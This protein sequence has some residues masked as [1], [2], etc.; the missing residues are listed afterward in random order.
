MNKVVLFS[1]LICF[2]FASC[3][4]ESDKKESTDKSEKKGNEKDSVVTEKTDTLIITPDYEKPY[5][6]YLS[7]AEKRMCKDM[8]GDSISAELFALH[9]SFDSIATERQM[10]IYFSA[11]TEFQDR[12]SLYL[13][14]LNVSE[15]FFN[16]V[17]AESAKE[18]KQEDEYFDEYRVSLDY[19]LD[20]L[21]PINKF[22]HGL[23]LAC[24]AECTEP[25]FDLKVN[26]LLAKVK[27]TEG[28]DDDDFFGLIVKTYAGDYEPGTMNAVWFE[29]TWDLGGM[30]LLGSGKH[31]E[32]FIATDKLLESKN[33]F[34]EGILYYR[35]IA[36]DDASSW[37]SFAHSKEKV[38]SELKSILKKVKLTEKESDNIRSQIRDI[39]NGTEDFQFDC[40]TNDCAWG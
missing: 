16:K 9:Q 7:K 14:D 15:E 10:L 37:N 39:E 12:A 22:L 30:S 27:E 5:P 21:E 36:M 23:I 34:T 20:N 13:S 31:T 17:M 35:Q 24:Q 3:G 32:F 40:K 8:L 2:A 19:I 4:G 33:I 29:A 18:E 28:E 1:V 25:C 6:D 11:L 38:L 26:G